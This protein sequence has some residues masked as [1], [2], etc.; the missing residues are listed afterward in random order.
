MS[1]TP[2]VLQALQILGPEEMLKLSEVIHVKKVPLKK[3]AG[4][5]LVVWDEEELKTKKE[6]V[7]EE[8]K[9]L[10]FTPPQSPPAPE[11]SPPSPEL[12]PLDGEAPTESDL[13][14]W[15]REMNKQFSEKAHQQEAA[16][17]YKKTNEIYAIKTK[18]E[19]GKTQVRYASTEGVLINKKQA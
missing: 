11:V 5:D 6:A 17:G 14:I 1:K 18:D 16:R 19:T 15:H 13:H 4:E 2:F 9:L 12:K 3:V 8:A 7:Q 10:L